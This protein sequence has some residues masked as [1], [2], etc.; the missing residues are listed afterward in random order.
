MCIRDRNTST[1]SPPEDGSRQPTRF[2]EASRRE[3]AETENLLRVETQHAA[4]DEAGVCALF[5]CH[6]PD[7]SHCGK[8]L[9]RI[10]KSCAAKGCGPFRFGC[11]TFARQSSW[12]RRIGSRSPLRIVPRK[13]TI[14]TLSTQFPV[15][16]INKASLR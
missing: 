13:K 8:R 6:E 5:R 7:P 2:S 3:L 10:G 16:A 12:L 11:R 4:P 14:R 9:E 1:Y 15:G